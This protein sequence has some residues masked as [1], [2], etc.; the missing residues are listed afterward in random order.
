MRTAAPGKERIGTVQGVSSRDHTAEDAADH[1]AFA[2]DDE[3]GSWPRPRGWTAPERLLE[4]DVATLPGVG[5]TLSKR[6]AAFGI[7]TIRDLLLHGPR[8]Y[9]SAA[10][11]VP[12]SRLGLSDGEVAIEGNVLSVR[13]RPLRGRR[14]LVS[15]VVADGSGGQITAS[16][17]NQ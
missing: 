17:F 16:F 2:G 5:P 6:L 7:R 8:R 14:S 11:R 9:E 3:G 4:L 15:A 1:A 10:E 12:I 13:S